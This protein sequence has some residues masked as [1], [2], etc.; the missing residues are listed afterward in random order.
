MPPLHSTPPAHLSIEKTK[1]LSADFY[2]NHEEHA[3]SNADDI[4][5][6]HSAYIDIFFNSWAGVSHSPASLFRIPPPRTLQ[7]LISWNPVMSSTL[8]TFDGN[9]SFRRTT[10][11]RSSHPHPLLPPFIAAAPAVMANSG[12]D[13]YYE[14][15]VEPEGEDDEDGQLY[16]SIN[17]GVEPSPSPSQSR[18]SFAPPVEDL[19]TTHLESHNRNDENTLATPQRPDP[20]FFAPVP[21]I[22]IS[23]LRG[24]NLPNTPPKVLELAPA[25]DDPLSSQASS[26]AI[27]DWDDAA[28]N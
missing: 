9:P 21:G 17:M 2:P 23:P 16:A 7:T 13:Y 5:S 12:D 18:F 1:A 26:D 20:P 10:T 4:S 6:N 27:E 14:T 11:R 24:D 8:L 15:R 28:A 22:F 19:P 25:G 3:I